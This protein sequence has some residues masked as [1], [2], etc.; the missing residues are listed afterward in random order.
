MDV[1]TTE[2]KFVGK[3]QFSLPALGDSVSPGS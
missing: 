1:I 3:I 2:I